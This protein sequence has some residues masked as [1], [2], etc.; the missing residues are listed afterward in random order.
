MKGIARIGIILTESLVRMY[1]L[2]SM[3][4]WSL[5]TFS[6]LFFGAIVLWC[7]DGLDIDGSV[8]M[9]GSRGVEVRW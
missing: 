3:V 8:V 5:T 2:T 7:C 4:N 9:M 6:A 1:A